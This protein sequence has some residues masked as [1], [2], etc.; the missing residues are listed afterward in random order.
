MKIDQK[1]ISI[2]PP[3]NLFHSKELDNR[4]SHWS[5]YGNVNTSISTHNKFIPPSSLLVM[6]RRISSEVQGIIFLL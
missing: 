6:E 2:P 3:C 1:K 4:L 5:N